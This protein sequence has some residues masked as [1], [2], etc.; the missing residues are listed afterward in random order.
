MKPIHD[1]VSL[2]RKHRKLPKRESAVLLRYYSDGKNMAIVID[3]KQ[4]WEKQRH[5]IWVTR[6]QALNLAKAIQRKLLPCDSTSTNSA[7]KPSA[8]SKTAAGN[9]LTSHK[10]HACSGS[11][12]PTSSRSARDSRSRSSSSGTRRK[13]ST[14]SGEP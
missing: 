12:Q 4:E 5:S 6:A 13:T 14:R 9:S 11:S 3:V 1:A 8:R 7:P 10:G 2:K